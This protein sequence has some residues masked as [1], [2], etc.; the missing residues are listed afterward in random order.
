MR[1]L[2]GAEIDNPLVAVKVEGERFEGWR[3]ATFNL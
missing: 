3:F 1:R 2:G